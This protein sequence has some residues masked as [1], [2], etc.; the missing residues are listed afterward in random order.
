MTASARQ[1]GSLTPGQPFTP[2]A[3]LCVST[4]NHLVA[5]D[6]HGPD[7]HFLCS[8][9]SPRH[10]EGQTDRGLRGEHGPML[11]TSPVHPQHWRRC[12]E[13]STDSNIG[14]DSVS[15]RG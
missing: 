6:D 15:G 2:L 13:L 7:G 11:A 5:G 8:K 1:L 3:F 9:A 14:L 10:L 4:G 12:E